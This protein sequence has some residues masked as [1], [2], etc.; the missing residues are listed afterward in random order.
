M[1]KPW[2]GR[3][4]EKTAKTLEKFSESVSFDQRLWQEDIEGS[5]VHAKMLNKQGIIND[6]E[7]KLISKG[8]KEIAKEIAEGKFQFKTE[9]E[10][11]HMNI[12]KALIE[13]IGSAGARLH[14]ARSRNDQVA[15]DLRLY[16]RKKVTEINGLLTEFEKT[17]INIA[18]KHIDII[19]P[20]YTHMQ[21]AQPVLLAHHLLAY[22]W[23]FERDRSR[24]T[25]ALK[26]INQC[27]LGACAIAG[28]SLPIDR[29][30]TA[31]ELG[32]ERVIPNSMDAVSDRDFVL[33]VL[34]CGAMI[35][36]HL[37]RLSEELII[38]ST[39]E[40]GYIELPD[41]FSTG[42]SMMPQKK[43]PDSAELI[44]GK[45]GRVYGNLISLLTTMKALPLTYN[46][47]MQEDKEPVFDTCDTVI[48]S[49]KIM[50]EMLPQVKF[51]VDKMKASLKTGF[52]TATD[53][54]EY[55]VKKGVPFRIAHEIVGKIVLYCIE[56]GKNLSELE[57]KEFK[58]FSDKIDENVY[59]ILTPEGS[60]TAKQSY[61]S[62]AKKFVKEQIIILKKSLGM[63]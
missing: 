42:S 19:M 59:E 27:P 26:R 48:M 30:Y 23:M 15:T 25:E 53:L 7:F 20:G 12:E 39:D 16:L 36:M 56:K 37:S 61:G 60:I 58:K 33:D 38:W 8:L 18:Q 2:G 28:T 44:R 40:F 50:I 55:L 21:K 46:R 54:A 9:L 13:K 14:T 57:I 24:L 4:K 51:N 49:L 10:D 63:K 43:N 32:M 52:L 45:T 29:D 34:Y 22:A 47:D 62:T 31:K 3:F 41:K 11:V 6:K 1:K 17:I 35:M 5:I